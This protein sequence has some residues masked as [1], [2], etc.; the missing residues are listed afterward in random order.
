MYHLSVKPI[1]ILCFNVMLFS[2]YH[3]SHLVWHKNIFLISHIMY[4]SSIWK[5]LVY[6]LQRLIQ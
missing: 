5:N 2:D 1:N 4:N 6:K 3:N